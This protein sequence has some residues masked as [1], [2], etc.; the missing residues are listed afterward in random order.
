MIRTAGAALLGLSWLAIALLT[1]LNRS[2]AGQS[3]SA[4]GL[5]ALGFVSG[6]A[7]AA[8]LAIGRGVLERIETSARWQSRAAE[9]ER[10]PDDGASP[11]FA[12]SC[13]VKSHVPGFQAAFRS[14]RTSSLL[15]VTM[16]NAAERC[17]TLRGR[18]ASTT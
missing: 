6:S 4:L 1:I 9:I 12:A 17:D 7:G 16:P 5:A 15:D 11:A 13:F 18:S 14:A 8:A 2:E 10:R 3:V